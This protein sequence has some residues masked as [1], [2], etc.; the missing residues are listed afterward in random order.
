MPQRLNNIRG[1]YQSERRRHMTG[2]GMKIS[3]YLSCISVFILAAA[4]WTVSISVA[5]AVQRGFSSEDAGLLRPLLRRGVVGLVDYSENGRLKGVRIV[6]TVKASPE[7]VFSVLADPGKHADLF[8]D[9]KEAS[10]KERHGNLIAYNWKWKTKFFYITGLNSMSLYPPRRIDMRIPRSDIGTGTLR[11]DIIRN[12]DKGSIVSLSCKWD[13]ESS[14]WLIKMLVRSSPMMEHA[15]HMGTGTMFLYAIKYASERSAR[16]KPLVRRKIRAK[17][18]PRLRPFTN[19]EM[20]AANSLLRDSTGTVVV[21]ERHKNQRL[22]QVSILERTDA[23]T[24][25]IVKTMSMPE[26]YP[27]FVPGVR[28]VDIKSSR[29]STINFGWSVGLPLLTME[30]SNRLTVEGNQIRLE[31]LKGDLKGSVWQYQFWKTGNK[32]QTV[33]A[34]MGWTNL[35][36]RDGMV[37][38]IIKREPYLEHG[39]NAAASLVFAHQVNKRSS[40]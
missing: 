27:D 34:Y 18:G 38:S 16:G 13:I 40:Q 20:T 29:G 37:R 4:L 35:I 22:R 25:S 33:S 26:K 30:S 2:K 32:N 14:N 5:A 3:R 8:V 31:A 9:F 36:T 21:V 7:T 12:G 6:S 39:M 19:R 15:L 17:G 11:W 1:S 24:G 23:A 28:D 10:V